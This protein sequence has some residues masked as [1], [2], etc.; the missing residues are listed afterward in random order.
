V[1]LS[2]WSQVNYLEMDHSVFLDKGVNK[3]AKSTGDIGFLEVAD[4]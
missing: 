3:R 4:S 1:Q 2:L